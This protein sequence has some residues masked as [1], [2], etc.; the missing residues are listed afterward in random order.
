MVKRKNLKP[1][2]NK[3]G[4]RFDVRHIEPSINY[5]SHNPIFSLKHMRYQGPYCISK[6]QEEKKSLILDTI[7]RLSQSTWAQIR[8]LSKKTG[9]E[10]I[11][12]HR[13][14]V[15][16]P[17]NITPEVPIIVARY[18]G[19]GGRLAGF[20]EKDIYHILLVGKDLYPH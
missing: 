11:P 8:S 16:F 18:D 6:C 12:R 10:K 13:F 14:K 7:L 9:F 1:P 2:S 19:D 17:P 20:R 5:D 4:K 3:T 15:S